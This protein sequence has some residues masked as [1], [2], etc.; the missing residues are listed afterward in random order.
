MKKT[1]VLH[2]SF[3]PNNKRK[4]AVAEFNINTLIY[5]NNYI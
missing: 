2:N 3:Q 4:R 5:K 1:I